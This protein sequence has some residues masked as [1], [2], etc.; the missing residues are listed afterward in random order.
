MDHQTEKNELSL[1][2]HKVGYARTIINNF[3]RKASRNSEGKINET[4]SVWFSIDDVRKLLKNLEA[5]YS[6]SVAVSKETAT[7]GVRIYF[8]NYGNLG[9][10]EKPEYKD[11]NTLVFVSTRAQKGDKN[12][13]FDYFGKHP[14]V[15][16]DIKSIALDP[17]NKGTLCPPDAGCDCDEILM[18]GELCDQNETIA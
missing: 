13:N 17:M 14:H 5:D 2:G 4:L 8:A 18:A 11:Q 7:D 16:K 1:N 9:E 3:A 15:S 12:K 10:I 6:A